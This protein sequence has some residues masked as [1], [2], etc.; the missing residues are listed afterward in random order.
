LLA[1][2]LS[3]ATECNLLSYPVDQRAE[4]HIA[5]PACYSRTVRSRRAKLVFA[6]GTKSAWYGFTIERDQSPPDQ[7]QDW[8]RFAATLRE[9][10]TIQTG[11]SDAMGQYGFQWR[12]YAQADDVPVTIVAAR[13]DTL[14]WDP[15]G[16]AEPISWTGFVDRLEALDT[17]VS[18]SVYLATRMDKEAAIALGPELPVPVVEVLCALLPLYCATAGLQPEA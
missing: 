14:L 10:A 7:Q 18:H 1:A 12:I 17:G 9:N 5:S 3:G 6:L 16:V 8:T 4:V 11:L 2:S 15:E 13:R